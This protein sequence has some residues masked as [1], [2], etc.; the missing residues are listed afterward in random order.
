MT[1]VYVVQGSTG[2]YSDR[3]EWCVR[4]YYDEDKAKAAVVSL[5]EWAANLFTATKI[6]GN[7]YDDGYEEWKRTTYPEIFELDQHFKQDYTGTYYSYST[8]EVE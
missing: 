1:K 4:G 3:D 8:I 6:L 2:E 5:S 7:E